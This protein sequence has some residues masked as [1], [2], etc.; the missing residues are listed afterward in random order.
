MISSTILMAYELRLIEKSCCQKIGGG[1][2]NI[3]CFNIPIF[4]FDSMEFIKLL[5]YS[6]LSAKYQE[7]NI[8]FMRGSTLSLAM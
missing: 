8:F 7:C 4:V 1:C 2:A 5:K 3:E 6:K